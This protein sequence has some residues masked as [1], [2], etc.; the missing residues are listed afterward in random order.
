MA[1]SISQL[2]LVGDE[3]IALLTYISGRVAFP[4]R[5]AVEVA[6]KDLKAT[7]DENFK[8]V[9]AVRL[10]D[11]PSE[12]KWPVE[13][14]SY[15]IEGEADVVR[16]KLKIGNPQLIVT[17]EGNTTTGAVSISGR[18]EASMAWSDYLIFRRLLRRFVE[19]VEKQW[20]AAAP[21]TAT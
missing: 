2:V 10:L 7:L 16:M 5:D 21:P 8:F 12:Q 13:E 17:Y 9:A 15:E 4:A 18:P 6:A 19:Y 20:F 3:P 11:L 14:L 1:T